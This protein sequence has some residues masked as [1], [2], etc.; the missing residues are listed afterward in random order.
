MLVFSILLGLKLLLVINGFKVEIIFLGGLIFLILVLVLFVRWII[1]DMIICIVF[2]LVF[3]NLIFIY[4][5][6]YLG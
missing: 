6:V 3:L 5:F 4:G 2:F 1:G